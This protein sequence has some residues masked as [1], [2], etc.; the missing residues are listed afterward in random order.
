MEGIMVKDEP[1]TIMDG[2]N[3]SPVD[4]KGANMG[5]RSSA[6][7]VGGAGTGRSGKQRALDTIRQGE[8]ELGMNT[9]LL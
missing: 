7:L 1:D 6:G 3:G 8:T 9:I 4:L 5:R 2:G